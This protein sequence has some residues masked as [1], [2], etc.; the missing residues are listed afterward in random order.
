MGFSLQLGDLDLDLVS[1]L[2]LTCQETVVQSPA[3]WV[4]G[5]MSVNKIL[6]PGVSLKPV[7]FVTRPPRV[8]T[9]NAVRGVDH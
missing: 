7:S 6:G 3:L 9:P 8:Q 2:L 4:S 5:F 1:A